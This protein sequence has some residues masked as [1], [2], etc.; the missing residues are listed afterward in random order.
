MQ[1]E[2]TSI[3]NGPISGEVKANTEIFEDIIAEAREIAK[4]H[5]NKRQ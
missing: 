1:A 5:N 2:I 4:I 3:V